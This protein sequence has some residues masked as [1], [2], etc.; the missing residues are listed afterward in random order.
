KNL[1]ELNKI[2]TAIT[3]SNFDNGQIEFYKSSKINIIYDDKLGWSLDGEHAES[4]GNVT[5]ENVHHGIK[6]I[7]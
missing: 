7:R 1:I 6:F 5:I 3:S 4:E 2:I